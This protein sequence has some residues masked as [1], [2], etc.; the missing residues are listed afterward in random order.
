MLEL[1]RALIDRG[2]AV[3]VLARHVDEEIETRA[4]VRRLARAPGPNLTDDLALFAL[5][6]AAL[7]RSS[8]DI[9]CVMG[10]CALPPHPFVY[11]AQFSHAG[12][13]STWTTAGRPS[14][15]HRAHGRM[16]RALERAVASRAER[17]LACSEG[18]A[19]EVGVGV[20]TSIVPNGIDLAEF[21]V[22]TAARRAAR[23]RALGLDDRAFVIAF[24][25]EYRTNRK[26]LEPLVRAIARGRGDEHVLVAGDGD[27]DAL[28]ALA[29]RLGCAHRVHPLG[30]VDVADVLP[31]ADAAAVPSLYEPFSIAALEAAATGLPVVIS[32]V[33]GAAAHLGD[34]AVVVDRPDDVD[35]LRA[36][37]DCVRDDADRAAMGRAARAAAERLSWEVVA[38]EAAGVVETAASGAPHDATNADAR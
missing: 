22:A 14:R 32:A 12:W 37:L 10:P 25:G 16:A 34:G 9:T 17:V 19:S 28:L 38:G 26:G 3:T 7:R 15:Y 8:F 6:S 29:H 21:P 1:A 11:Y 33:A 2:H 18:V 5:A 24:A 23:R 4:R 20:G 36:A 30:F 31:A 35:A 13:Q 27:P